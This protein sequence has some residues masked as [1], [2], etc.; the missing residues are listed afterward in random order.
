LLW[1]EPYI[2]TVSRVRVEVLRALASRVTSSQVMAYCI[3]NV[4]RPKL[5]VGPAPGY[6]GRRNS[7]F[8]V[9]AIKRYGY[10][11]EERFLEKAYDRA[12]Q[13]FVGK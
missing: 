11:L 7:V 3:P 8:Y 1:F 6:V 9:E 2:N 10:M 12:Q 13:F 5:S 4:P